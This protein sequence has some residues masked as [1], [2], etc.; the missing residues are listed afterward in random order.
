MRVRSGWLIPSEPMFGAS[1]L[2]IRS[3]FSGSIR[4]LLDQ[5]YL[6]VIRVA[7]AWRIDVDVRAV[8]DVHRN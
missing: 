6:R 8:A 5:P 3:S 1:F 7:R 2:P 4:K